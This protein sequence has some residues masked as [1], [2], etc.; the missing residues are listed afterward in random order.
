MLVE[1]RALPLPLLFLMR[2]SLI[3]LL[4]FPFERAPSWILH[5]IFCVFLF[6]AVLHTCNQFCMFLDILWN[7]ITCLLSWLPLSILHSSDSPVLFLVAVFHWFSLQNIIYY[8]NA[9][10][11][12]NIQFTIDRHLGCFHYLLLTM[13]LWT[14]SVCCW[15]AE[16]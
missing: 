10:L 1:Y 2:P 11:I 9:P 7:W 16:I 5:F 12:S 15:F 3:W 8:M 4:S 14:L 6:I 13:L